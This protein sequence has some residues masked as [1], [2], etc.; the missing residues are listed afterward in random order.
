MGKINICGD[1][2][3]TRCRE[4][5][6]YGDT[7]SAYDVELCFPKDGQSMTKRYIFED[8]HLLDNHRY[9]DNKTTP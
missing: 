5:R 9:V 6:K 4:F 8:E 7:Y 2:L 3:V 1:I